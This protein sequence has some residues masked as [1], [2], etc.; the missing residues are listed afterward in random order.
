[1]RKEKVIEFDY[2]KFLRGDPMRSR[3]YGVV[4]SIVN[5]IINETRYRINYKDFNE[6]RKCINDADIRIKMFFEDTIESGIEL[7]GKIDYLYALVKDTRRD[8]DKITMELKQ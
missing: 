4:F 6:A 1:M 3:D 5:G 7:N 8:M 2:E